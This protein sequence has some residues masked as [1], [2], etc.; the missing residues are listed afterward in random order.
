MPSQRTRIL[1]AHIPKTRE[2]NQ[3]KPTFKKQTFIPE[4]NVLVSTVAHATEI[5][6][7]RT[8]ETMVF[9]ARSP[10]DWDGDELDFKSHGYEQDPTKLTEAHEAIVKKWKMKK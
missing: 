9:K 1:L 8:S 10:E 3:M 6:Y 7:G 4:K 2:V 5:G